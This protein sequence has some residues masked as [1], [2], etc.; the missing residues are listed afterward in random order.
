M[1]HAVVAYGS[2]KDV[3]EFAVYI[4][5]ELGVK[6]AG[7]PDFHIRRYATLDVEEARALKDLAQL[8]GLGKRVFVI[9]AQAI[10][11]E[12]QNALLKIV[13]EPGE[14]VTFAFLVPRGA[15]IGTIVSRVSEIPFLPKSRTH[16]DAEAFLRAAPPARSKLIERLVK[17]K[18]KEAAY[19]LL[20]DMEEVLAADLSRPST[21]AALEEIGRMRSYITDPSASLKMILEHVAL[22]TPVV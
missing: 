3:K 16:K 22:A 17:D 20:C 13:E 4:A 1:H 19:E 2:P 8:S 11:R 9:A 5:H 6:V 15:L 18:D 12:A 7:N 21:R 10:G 14:G